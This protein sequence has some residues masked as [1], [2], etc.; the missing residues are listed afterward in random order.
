M[1]SEASTAGTGHPRSSVTGLALAFAAMW[2][3]ILQPLSHVSLLRA[4]MQS[5]GPDYTIICTID[6]PRLVKA[7]DLD[8]S[9]SGDRDP[10]SQTDRPQP[11]GCLGGVVV[12][13]LP[14]ALVLVFGVEELAPAEPHPFAQSL[15]LDSSSAWRFPKP[16]GPPAF[17][18]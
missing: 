3:L 11:N 17:L 6:G 14:V 9:R 8:A 16:R 5:A 4:L 2:V 13:S 10:L 15:P 18:T 12:V 7:G 1:G